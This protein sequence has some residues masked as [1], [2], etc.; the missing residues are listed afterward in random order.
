[1]VF[2]G[3]GLQ[4]FTNA[5]TISIVNF[6]V[7]GASTLV[8]GTQVLTGG[9][10]TLPAGATLKTAHTAGLDGSIAVA[11]TALLHI[12]EPA[13]VSSEPIINPAVPDGFVSDPDT[14]TCLPGSMVNK[15]A[16][17]ISRFPLTVRVGNN[18]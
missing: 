15:Q 3:T 10:F 5:G 9:K 6:E 12:I 11:G 2:N 4:N 13:P 8:M 18:S 17:V 16:V 14:V 1:M 7:G